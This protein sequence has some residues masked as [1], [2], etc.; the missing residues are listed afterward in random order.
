MN[1]KAKALFIVTC[2]ILLLS[3]LFLSYGIKLHN[4]HID[5]ALAAQERGMD[6]TVRDFEKY[7]YAPYQFRLGNMV[8]EHPEL[9]RAFV[10]RDRE[11]LLEQTRPLYKRR[12]AENPFLHA[13]HFILPDGRVFLRVEEP[14]AHGDD[15]ALTREMVRAVITRQEPVAGFDIGRHGAMYWVARPVYHQ[16]QFVGVTEL[17]IPAEQVKAALEARFGTDAAL[18]VK[19]SD[20]VKARMVG[21]G[22]HRRG[23]Q[24]LI[25]PENSRYRKLPE[26]MELPAGRDQRLSLGR[27]E[28]VLHACAELVDFRGRPIGRL[29]VMQDITEEVAHRREFIVAALFASGL[30]LALSFAVLYAS[31]DTLIGRLERSAAETRAAKEEVER[32]RDALDLRVRERTSELQTANRTLEEQRTFLGTVLESLTHP[33]YVID[34]ATYRILLANKA[35]NPA[36]GETAGLTCHAMTHGNAAPCVGA[37]HPCALQEVKRTGKPI[38]LEHQHRVGEERRV[39]Q[40]FAYPVL[41]AAGAV[42]QVIEYCIDVTEARESAKLQAGLERQL[43]RAQ[44]MEAIGTL[45]GGIAHDF[46]NILAAIIGHAELIRYDLPPSSKY[47]QSI[48]GVLRAGSRA[49]DLVQQILAFSRQTE[50]ERRPLLVQPIVKEALKLLRASIPASVE[51]RESIQPCAAILSDPILIHQIVMNLCTNAF[52]AMRE[53]GA[54][55]LGVSLAPI[56]IGEGDQRA[57]FGLLAPGRYVKLEVSDTGCG[58][59]SATVERIFEPYFT[60]KPV[61]EGTG[62]GLA[63]VHG[64]VKSHGGHVSVYSELGIGSTFKVYFPECEP[65]GEKGPAGPAGGAGGAVPAPEALPGGAE[66]ILLVDDER[67]LVEVVQAMLQSLGYRV[68]VHTDVFKALEAFTRDPAAYDLLITDMTMPEMTGDRLARRVLELKPGFPIVLCTGFSEIIDGERARKIGV[69]EFIMKPILKAELAA[70]VRK[71]LDRL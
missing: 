60:T 59:D 51:I 8:E 18:A 50:Q 28:Y 42:A 30:L 40:I 38:V 32:S 29:L 13:W 9:T 49:R 54:G 14:D 11:R 58:M 15:V 33:F 12:Q 66:R 64:I 10:D 16:G 20:W 63:V 53:K 19:T 25:V 23:E 55:V 5:G 65:R 44:K 41:D 61:G 36:G 35:A 62:L 48:E 43:R 2:L 47:R 4:E 21:S 39:F 70:S 31:F 1:V 3:G 56:T 52:H 17:G 69:R 45:A 37:D 34:A 71:A 24:V 7:F 6:A 27:N 26:G 22:F 68:E 67:E 46:N 57:E